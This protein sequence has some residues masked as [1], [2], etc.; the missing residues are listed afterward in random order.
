[1]KGDERVG[2]CQHGR[3]LNSVAGCDAADLP[4][5]GW[6]WL[7]FSITLHREDPS[8]AKPNPKNR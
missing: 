6:L 3:T 8:W 2:V 7:V 1:M 5:H 4:C